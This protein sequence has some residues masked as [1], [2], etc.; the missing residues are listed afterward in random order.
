[1]PSDDDE[2]ADIYAPDLYFFEQKGPFS[3]PFFNIFYEKFP[4]HWDIA[5]FEMSE[6]FKILNSN[7]YLSEIPWYANAWE[8]YANL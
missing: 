7:D 1:M 8:T 3:K 6:I 2:K 4:K 5:R